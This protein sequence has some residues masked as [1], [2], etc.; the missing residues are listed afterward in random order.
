LIARDERVTTAWLRLSETE[1]TR[2]I[3]NYHQQLASHPP[4][5]NPNLHALMHG[6][7]D[8]QLAA[9]DP[10]EV[11]AT[12]ERLMLAGLGR[13]EAIHAIASVVAEALFKVA[14][15]GVAF[16]RTR[17]ARELA[18]LRPEQWRFAP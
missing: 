3:E 4:M 7:V 8:N 13:H 17:T 6:I 11:P 9:R 15:E 14:K 1:R 18:R 10:A 5:P 16:D 12:L 2:A